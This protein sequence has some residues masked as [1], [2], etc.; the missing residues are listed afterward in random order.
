MKTLHLNLK[1]KKFNEILNGSNKV[2]Y[3][4]LNEYYSKLFN[5]FYCYSCEHIYHINT[6]PISFRCVHNG[7][8]QSNYF[9]ICKHFKLSLPE[10][11]TQY[12]TVTI[13]N[14]FGKYRPLF[15][16]ELKELQINKD[17]FILVLGR[18]F[19]KVNC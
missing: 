18:I 3:L 1:I 14:G 19:C 9:S 6:I 2:I 7:K 11:L 4:E 13:H 12:D 17:N 8:P 15:V 5:F 16:I 10:S